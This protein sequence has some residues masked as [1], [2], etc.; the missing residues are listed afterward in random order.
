MSVTS[1]VGLARQVGLWREMQSVANNIANL[2]TTGFRREGLIYSEHVRAT[3]DGPSVSIAHA[4]GRATSVAQGTLVQT[5]GAF[6]FA[7]EGAGYFLIETPQGEALTRAGQFTPSAD[8]ELVTADGF[9]LLDAGGAP[10]FVPPGLGPVA[11]GADG[12]LS[13]GGQPLTQIG[14]WQPANPDTLE[15][16]TGVLFLAPDGVEPVEGRMLQGFLEASNVDPVREIARMIE[17]QNAYEM[18]RGFSRQEDERLR[19]VLDTLSR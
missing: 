3:G 9:R 4:N 16:R 5:D 18:G 11:L 14:L 17:V 1:S 2:S 19:A 13:A 7:I 8:G 15:R 6:D 10:V 12:T